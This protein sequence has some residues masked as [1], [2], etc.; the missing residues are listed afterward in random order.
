MQP[1]LG[2]AGAADDAAVVQLVPGHRLEMLPLQDAADGLGRAGLDHPGGAGR[3]LRHRVAVDAAV[4]A[5][6]DLGAARG[7][8]AVQLLEH[9]GVQPVV[10]VHKGEVFAR[11]GL[12]AGVARAGQA[13]VRLVDDLHPGIGGGV[14]VADGAAPV[15]RAVVHQDHLEVGKGLG[16]DR[17]H[18]AAQIALHVIYRDDHTDLWHIGSPYCRLKYSRMCPVMR[19]LAWP[20]P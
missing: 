19:R 13:T 5:L 14:F 12:D 9:V 15:G 4:T 11:G 1:S 20:S 8:Q 3:L 2:V 7:A 6:G 18:T 10:A 16:Q 17:I